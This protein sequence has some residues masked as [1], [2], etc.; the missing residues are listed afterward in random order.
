MIAYLVRC[1]Y[2][3]THLM[4][5][6]LQAIIGSIFFV[7]SPVSTNARK[8]INLVSKSDQDVLQKTSFTK[9][10]TVEPVYKDHTWG[11]A[12]KWPL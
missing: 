4:T 10:I 9:L 7:P 1:V 11:T 12:K 8:I 6:T 5:T 3:A 2:C